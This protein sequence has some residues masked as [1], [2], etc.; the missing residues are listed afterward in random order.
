MRL[1][2]ANEL[3]TKGIGAAGDEET[4][5]SVRGVPKYLIIPASQMEA[6]EEFKLEQ[7]LKQVQDEVAAGN[8]TTDL[9]AHLNDIDNV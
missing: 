6:Y 8:F 2:T 3:K 4:V 9:D 1:I 7:A 5:V